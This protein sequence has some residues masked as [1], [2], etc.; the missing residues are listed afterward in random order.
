MQFKIRQAEKNEVDMIKDLADNKEVL[1]EDEETYDVKDFENMIDADNG[2]VLVGEKGGEIIGVCFGQF[3]VLQD[4]CDLLGLQV[5]DKWRKRG[6]RK[7]LLEAFVD[8]VKQH[9]L[10]TIDVFSPPT[11]Q[12]F[13]EEEGFEE[14]TTHVQMK[15]DL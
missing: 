10:S 9:G 3:D 5:K 1:R 15:K 6:V 2:V 7:D 11:D 4:W 12:G 8:R 13:F 14:V